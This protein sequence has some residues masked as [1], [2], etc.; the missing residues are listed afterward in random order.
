MGQRPAEATAPLSYDFDGI[1]HFV[2]L[3][4][5]H[6]MAWHRWFAADGIQPL[7]VRYEDL[8]AD[9]LEVTRRILD[10]LELDLPTG[11]TIRAGTKRLADQISAAGSTVIKLI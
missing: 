5:K 1:H 10:F 9:P 3:I 8:D 4:A 2:Q 7:I 11:R 6:N